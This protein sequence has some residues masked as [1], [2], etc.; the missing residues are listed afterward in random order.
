MFI[1]LCVFMYTLLP[2]YITIVRVQVA[3]PYCKQNQVV[4]WF[5]YMI[6]PILS[7]MFWRQN[8]MLANASLK[9]HV[10]LANIS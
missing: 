4:E 2:R 6:F 1:E 9:T 7:P 8:Y 5:R 3:L 10:V